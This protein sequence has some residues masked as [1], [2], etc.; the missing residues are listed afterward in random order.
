MKRNALRALS[1]LTLVA[2]AWV[3]AAAAQQAQPAAPPTPQQRVAMLKQ[4]LAASQA[5]L[6]NYEWI[7]TTVIA[8]GGVEK[9]RKQNT[10]YYGVDGELQKVP[11]ASDAPAESGP[12][13]PLRKKLAANK[14][15]E[16]TAY[17]Q[18]AAALVHEYVPPD[19]NRIQ[20][21]VNS[22]NFSVSPAGSRVRL[23]FKNYLKPN[24]TL[25]VDV[26]V[27]TNRLIG[28]S[29]SS[30][31]QEAKDAIQLDAQMGVLPDGTIFMHQATLAAPA[32]DITVTIQNTGY[33]HTGG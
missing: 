15:E 13:G 14:K 16:V 30:Y 33:R 12:R 4:W 23:T 27:P 2:A 9:S 8:K 31:L 28:M 19:Q 3:S 32:Q 21:A 25:N 1:S 24:D 20:Q 26:E 22:G 10:C 6:R 18:S 5:Q 17:M 29:I 11:L 7:E